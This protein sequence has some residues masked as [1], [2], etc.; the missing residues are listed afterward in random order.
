MTV[1]RLGY[2]IDSSGAVK[3]AGDLDKMSA[4]AVKAEAQQKALKAATGQLNA[5]N[6]KASSGFIKLKAS[7]DSAF[8]AAVKLNQAH[9]LLN[10]ELKAGNITAQQ[11]ADS[12]GN[13]TDRYRSQIAVA[14]SATKDVVKFGG[15]MNTSASQTANLGA[16]INDIGVMLAAG[17]NPFQLAVQQGTQINQVF[18][19]MGG[20]K[21]ALSGLAA[22]FMSMVNPMSLATIGIIAGGAALVQWGVSAISAG[23][24]TTDLEG[25][26]DTLSTV[27]GEVDAAAEVL[28]LSIDDLVI[29]YGVA[30]QRVSEFAVAQAELAASQ[31]Q[32]RL[33]DQ[34]Q[35]LSDEIE[36]FSSVVDGAD[37]SIAGGAQVRVNYNRAIAEIAAT[38]KVGRAE[39][40]ILIDKFNDLSRAGDF[41]GQQGALNN[42]IK[43]LEDMKIP[44]DLLPVDLQIAVDEMITL[45][46]ETDAAKVAMDRLAGAAANV[47]VGTP[48]FLQGFSG[49]ELLPPD[50][51][52]GG[53]TRS[54]GGGASTD[55][56]EGNLERLRESLR[57]EREVVEEWRLE[58]DTLLA[59]RRAIEILGIEGHNEAKLRLETEYQER[60][61]GIQD[62]GIGGN[63]GILN[64]FFGEAAGLMQAG[65]DKLF[66]IGQAAAI[67]NAVVSGHSAAVAAWEKGMQAGGP[68]LAAAY[69]ALSIARTAAQISAIKSASSSSAAGSAS[70][71]ATSASAGVTASSETT[72]PEL[73]RAIISI[74]GGRSKLTVEELNDIAKG[75]QDLS[76]DGVIIE[77]F[78]T[79]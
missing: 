33:S 42:V 18:A 52:G 57:T 9:D 45:G 22:G 43:T 8:A 46:R 2:E 78:V 50:P 67:A 59:D 11:H 6:G 37:S 63:L 4:S 1:A 7:E 38:F 73:T 66:K 55:P 77:G 68:P 14:G 53:R 58:Q 19:Q 13:L 51:N 39:A 70:S 79:A 69:T 62:E 54:G 60:L 72:Q 65:N 75:L 41:E 44:L 26:L 17:Q 20:G 48:L 61:K 36:R 71:S 64:N 24:S 49:N 40:D 32:R 16:Q 5:L 23:Q 10:A 15:A 21:Q 74:Q 31:A 35:V 29:K 56:F 12:I 28:E 76:D 3:A 30:A 34:F 25:R 27:M 47:T